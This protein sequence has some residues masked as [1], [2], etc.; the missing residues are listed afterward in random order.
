MKKNLLLIAVAVAFALVSCGGS[1]EEKKTDEEVQEPVCEIEN[2]I[3]VTVQDYYYSMSDTLIFNSSDFEVKASEYNWINDS[4]VSLKLSN[5]ET[6]DLV[7]ARSADQVDINIE[8]NAR[9]GEKLEEGYYGY[10]TYDAGKWS[11]VTLTT[12]YGTVWFNW[13]MG[14][15]EQ[16]GVTIEHIEKDA[17]CGTLALNNE[18]PENEM[19]GIVRIN[20]TFVF[21][22]AE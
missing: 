6:K 22:K 2:S 14:M 1:T 9:N 10:H 4:T 12:A 20:G 21:K 17:I 8:I 7:G 11:R 18:K 3:A 15:P 13:V 5:Y 19:I 16:G